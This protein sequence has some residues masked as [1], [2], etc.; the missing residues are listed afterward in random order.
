MDENQK[1]SLYTALIAARAANRA[2]V[3][4]HAV[5][6]AKGV[7]TNADIEALRHLHLREFDAAFDG[8]RHEDANREIEELREELD[9][10]WQ[11]SV[12]VPLR[13]A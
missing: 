11:M 3:R 10:L 5:L 9:K 1:A 4:L 12:Q 13:S 7:L 6:A 8:V 2:A